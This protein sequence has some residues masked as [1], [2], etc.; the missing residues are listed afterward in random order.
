ML[1]GILDIF[2]VEGVR[3]VWV[4]KV[5]KIHWFVSTCRR[6]R[7]FGGMK[8]VYHTSCDVL[9]RRGGRS[10][11]LVSLISRPP[12]ARSSS[13]TARRFIVARHV[14]PRIVETLSTTCIGA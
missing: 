1:V 8:L 7:T 6:L 4:L 13:H 14:R 10:L 12:R 11:F 5:N 2:S 9:C 3:T